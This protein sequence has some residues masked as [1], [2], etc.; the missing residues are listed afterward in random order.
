MEFLLAKTRKTSQFP[1]PLRQK[2][3]W[4]IWQISPRA[5]YIY[6]FVF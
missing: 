2:Y 4:I 6:S 3:Q 1:L 5:S